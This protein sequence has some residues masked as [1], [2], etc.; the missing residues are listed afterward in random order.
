MFAP[1]VSPIMIGHSF[2]DDTATMYSG[3]WVMREKKIRKGKWEQGKWKGDSV[4]C[5]QETRINLCPA[6]ALLQSE[7]QIQRHAAGKNFPL[8]YIIWS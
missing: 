8:S 1:H 5:E 4:E 7:K 2:E 3:K 6:K